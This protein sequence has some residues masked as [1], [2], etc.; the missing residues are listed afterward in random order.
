MLRKV[1]LRVTCPRVAALSAV[2][3][4]LHAGT[5]SITGFVREDLGQP[6]RQAVYDLPRALAAASGASGAASAVGAAGA[7]HPAEG[8][9]GALR[10]AGRGQLTAS[11]AGRAV[12]SPA[13]MARSG[14]TPCLTAFGDHGFTI[15]RPR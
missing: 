4:H 6:S 3:D 7:A 15:D 13:S 10:A 9:R 1:A 5:D 12:P 2:H 11:R 14:A 8:P